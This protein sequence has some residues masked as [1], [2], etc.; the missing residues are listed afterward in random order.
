[1]EKFLICV[2]V[3]FK[4]MEQSLQ[5]NSPNGWK[6][7]VTLRRANSFYHYSTNSQVFPSHMTRKQTPKEFWSSG[8]ISRT[9]RLK[10][11]LEESFK[12]SGEQDVIQIFYA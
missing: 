6:F 11:N 1:M 9:I 5:E 3:P 4:V 10:Y 12:M 8:R 7:Q 2:T